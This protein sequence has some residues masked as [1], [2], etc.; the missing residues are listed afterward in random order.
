MS[1]KKNFGQHIVENIPIIGGLLGGIFDDQSNKKSQESAQAHEIDMWNR[2]NAYNTPAEQMKRLKEA[3]LNPNLMYGQGSTGNASGKP[4]TIQRQPSK[5]GKGL[6]ET[7]MMALQKHQQQVEN[8]RADDLAKGQLDVYRAQALKAMSETNFNNLSLNDRLDGLKMTNRKLG[9]QV[10][11][12]SKANNYRLD[13]LAHDV[14]QGDLKNQQS[15]QALKIAGEKFNEWVADKHHRKYM[16]GNEK[17]MAKLKKEYQES[18]NILAKKGLTLSSSEYGALITTV[19]SDPKVSQKID[20]A[21][22]LVTEFNEGTS[23]WKKGFDILK[24]FEFI[25]NPTA[26]IKKLK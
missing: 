17:E 16:Q 19:M 25:T 7:S 3:G 14:K 22:D 11:Y 15:E 2:N 26:L 9:Q 4:Q 21:L 5:T 12:D 18:V 10:D 6:S 1:E 8:R 13:I 20:E 24:Q 23:M